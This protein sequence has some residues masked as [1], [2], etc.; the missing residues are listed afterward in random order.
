MQEPTRKGF[1]RNDIPA[2]LL[3]RRI[4]SSSG[5]AGAPIDPLMT[6]CLRLGRDRR[7]TTTYLEMNA[8]S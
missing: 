6:L 7:G 1:A 3:T 8:G 5:A 2:L 4:Q